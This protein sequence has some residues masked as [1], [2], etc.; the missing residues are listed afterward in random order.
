VA[1]QRLACNLCGSGE[2]RPLYVIDGYDIVRCAGCGLAY[3]AEPV[4]AE[5]L[6]AYYGK[7]YFTGGQDKG[8][9]D[10]F[11][12]RDK[13]KAH[14]RSLLPAL[15]RHLRSPQPRVLDVGCAAGFFLEVVRE[16]GWSGKGV[17]LSAFAAGHARTERGLDVFTG[18]LAQ[19]GFADQSFDLVTLWD[20]IEHLTD[21][22]AEIEHAHR[23]LRPEGLLAISTGDLGGATARIYGKR[24]AL[25]APPGHLFYFSRDT[26]GE[27]LR[28]TGFVPLAW[29]SDGAFLLNEADTP[30]ARRSAVFRAVAW[31]HHQRIPNAVLRRLGLGSIITVIARRCGDN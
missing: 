2:A 30:Q 27:L 4:T 31:L 28:R 17:E 12:N 15:R 13:R 29:L 20:V 26:L 25:L 9:A 1:T 24:W 6:Q 22:R 23:V 10:Y 11:A 3:V 14:Y 21:P 16:A 7:A 19:A 18:T 8:Y 5:Q